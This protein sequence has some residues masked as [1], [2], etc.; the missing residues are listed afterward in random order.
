MFKR[1]NPGENGAAINY[2]TLPSTLV[3]DNTPIFVFKTQKKKKKKSKANNLSSC[4]SAST[5]SVRPTI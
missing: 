1:E 5:P 2:T 3:K 4:C